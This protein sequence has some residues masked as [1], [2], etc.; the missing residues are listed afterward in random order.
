[1]VLKR[2]RKRVAG[3]EVEEEDGEGL[4]MRTKKV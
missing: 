4:D 1:V 2:R 3:D